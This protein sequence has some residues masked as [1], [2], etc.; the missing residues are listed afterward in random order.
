[1]K[2]ILAFFSHERMFKINIGLVIFNIL[3]AFVVNAALGGALPLRFFAFAAFHLFLAWLLSIK[4]K[5][6]VDVVIEI[7]TD[8][9]K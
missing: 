9:E 8:K 6:D 3:C 2:K 7:D 5:K 4:S 1:M